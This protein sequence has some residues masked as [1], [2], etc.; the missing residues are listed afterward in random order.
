MILHH[1]LLAILWRYRG[2][3]RHSNTRSPPSSLETW[4]KANPVHL[5][6]ASK[7]LAA[8]LYQVNSSH[9][10]N[11]EHTWKCPVRMWLTMRSTGHPLCSKHANYAP[12]SKNTPEKTSFTDPNRA[13]RVLLYSRWEAKVENDMEFSVNTCAH[14]SLSFPVTEDGRKVFVDFVY[15]LWGQR[16]A[17]E[18]MRYGIVRTIANIE[19]TL[20]CR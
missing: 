5:S 18:S 15:N 13:S 9:H 14:C 10:M 6:T 20:P 3:S 7:Q 2:F 12:R 16:G 11:M 1:V 8:Q 19:R 17:A 4:G